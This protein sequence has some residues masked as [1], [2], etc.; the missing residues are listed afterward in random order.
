MVDGNW[1]ILVRCYVR[2]D[3]VVVMILDT[4]LYYLLFH[5]ESS[6]FLKFIFGNLVSYFSNFIL[7]IVYVINLLYH[8][9]YP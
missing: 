3:D 9:K 2:V 7:V 1:L 8:Y 4:I 5:A 6:K